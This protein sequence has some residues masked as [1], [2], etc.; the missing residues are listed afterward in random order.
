MSDPTLEQLR[1]R[2]ARLTA[3]FT[4][5]KGVVYCSSTPQYATET[6]LLTGMGSQRF[7]GRW[8]PIG[9]AMVYASLTPEAAMAE[10]LAHNRYYGI[11]IEDAMPRTFVAIEVK[12][13][14]L[15]DLRDGDVRRRLQV[16]EDII[17]TVDWRA[18]VRA[19]REP[20]TQRLTRAAYSGPWEGFIVPSAV[21]R[22]GQNLLIFPD[23]LG[24]DSKM[25]VTN[26]DKLRPG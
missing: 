12:L 1:T 5:F 7:G 22:N 4:A 19:G 9:I 26:A 14:T 3:S 18:E 15:L 11:P 2:L 25:T 20:I 24:P 8:N 6:D 16:S 21:A 13:H 10:T 23:K 17:T